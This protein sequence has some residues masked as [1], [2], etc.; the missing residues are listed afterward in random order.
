MIFAV[1]KEVFQENE[2]LFEMLSVHD[3]DKIAGTY[4]L[5]CTTGSF[6]SMTGAAG[7]LCVYIQNC[8]NT[9]KLQRNVIP[10]SCERSHH[11][12]LVFIP[13]SGCDQ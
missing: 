7:E 12:Y 11:I 2:F 1:T 3:S 10:R 13:F 8:S 4:F 5:N 9:R 6:I